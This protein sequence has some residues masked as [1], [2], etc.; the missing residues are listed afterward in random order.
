MVGHF[1]SFAA[2]VAGV[3]AAPALGRDPLV[4]DVA[5]RAAVAPETGCKDDASYSDNGWDCRDWSSEPCRVGYAP[6]STPTRIARLVRSCPE[7][8]PDVTPICQEPRAPPKFEVG[9]EDDPTY[10]DK[11]AHKRCSNSGVNTD[12]QVLL[13]SLTH[14]SFDSLSPSLFL[15][16]AAAGSVAIGRPS[17]AEWAIRRSQQWNASQLSY[18]HARSRAPT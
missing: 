17:T 15:S 7:S 2:L 1:C 12:G 16:I 11:C 8:C 5:P 4:L 9:C 14:A 18:A 3:R 10:S 6:V 13:S